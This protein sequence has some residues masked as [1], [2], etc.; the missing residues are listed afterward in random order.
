M[1]VGNE[2][3][4]PLMTKVIIAHHVADYDR[5][6]PVFLAHGDARRAAGATGHAVC[7]DPKDPNSVVI[8]NDFAT[9]EGAIAF[10]QD[11]SLP[12]AMAA[13]GVE[14]APTVYVVSESDVASY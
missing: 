14:G 7:R 5:W 12:G 6:L 1:P 3:G 10:T 9:L 2:Q 8:V 13:G 11:A 4:V